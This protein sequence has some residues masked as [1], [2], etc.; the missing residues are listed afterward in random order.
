MKQKLIIL[1]MILLLTSFVSAAPISFT[2]DTPVEDSTSSTFIVNTTIGESSDS[3]SFV[4]I[5]NDVSLWLTGESN[6]GVPVDNSGHNYTF[7]QYDGGASTTPDGHFGSALTFSDVTHN[8]VAIK[9]TSDGYENLLPGTGSY[10]WVAWLK[11]TDN[12]SQDFL[13]TQEVDDQRVLFRLRAGGYMQI[14]M[15]STNLCS[16]TYN[17]LNLYDGEWNHIAMV[18]DRGD[19][20]FKVYVNGIKHPYNLDMSDCTDFSAFSS[21][22]IT[23]LANYFN[24]S[25]DEIML[26]KRA[27]NQNEIL[28]LYNASSYG[29]NNDYTE[30]VQILGDIEF[31]ATNVE[32]DTS[33]DSVSRNFTFSNVIT[34]LITPLENTMV[35]DELVINISAVENAS[36]Y[37]VFNGETLTLINDSANYFS[38]T[39]DISLLD[40]GN[41][42][43]F[44]NCSVD[45]LFET[46]NITFIKSDHLIYYVDK[47][48]SVCS[49]YYTALQST[50]IN[51]PFCT[52]YQGLETVAS[53]GDEV[54][55]LDGLYNTTGIYSSKIPINGTAEKPIIISGESNTVRTVI[56]GSAYTSE[57][58]TANF[59]DYI[60]YR[61]FNLTQGYNDAINIHGSSNISEYN[62]KGLIFENITAYK[63]GRNG[64]GHYATAAGDG[65]SFHEYTSG[66]GRHLDLIQN[67]KS[68][69]TDVGGTRTN[70]SDLYVEGAED[71]GIW[72]V[73]LSESVYDHDYAYHYLENVVVENS[74]S[75]LFTE[76]TTD[77]EN[78][79]CT[80]NGLGLFKNNS[81]IEITYRPTTVDGLVIENTPVSQD[82]VYVHTN[83]TFEAINGVIDGN[84][85]VDTGGN[86]SFINVSTG[87]ITV[88]DGELTKQW[89]YE[90]LPVNEYGY[91]VD[92][93][94]TITDN[95]SIEQIKV[96]DVYYLTELENVD[97]TETTYTYTIEAEYDGEIIEQEITSIT[98]NRVVT[99]L[100]DNSL[101]E[102]TDGV[103][104]VK[105]TS[106][107]AFGLIAVMLLAAIAMTFIVMIK[108]G[109]DTGT[110]MTL[111]IL[112]I[113]VS[114]ILIVGF[115]IMNSVA[116]G[117]IAGV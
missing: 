31:T 98:D 108:D 68:G 85:T 73:V 27:L 107:I 39:K 100:F 112:A 57:M 110:L 104:N 96:G 46:E 86:V 78:F 74:P 51:T 14:Y 15:R 66:V 38:A 99:I 44:I 61:Y 71:L 17:A 13:D 88:I 19:N 28:S 93:V 80:N 25:M 87:P 45:N 70:Y 67:Y 8:R 77:F 11:S 24:G 29:L 37:T 63:N 62:V 102:T 36:C 82:A 106:Y 4:N 72:F 49:N 12:T 23:T 18:L 40:D 52:I 117:I 1:L 75:C 79:R 32:N 95:S 103:L 54:K 69:L 89:I 90:I 97:G 92:A 59:R 35:V 55:I 2:G 109:A 9:N 81:Q 83:G 115:I 64:D 30:S 6:A 10:T 116:I 60:T 84:I 76:V 20:Y 53:P 3:F 5:N 21:V 22:Y 47:E 33:Y 26:F 91:P 43:V 58:I 101:I 113:G 105:S 16:V 50:N 42:N 41:H 114:V 7:T 94:I 65:V 48:N 111:G 34:N 56:D